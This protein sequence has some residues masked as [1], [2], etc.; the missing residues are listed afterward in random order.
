MVLPCDFRVH[1]VHPVDQFGNRNFD[2]N[3]FGS[4]ISTRPGPRTLWHC[5]QSFVGNHVKPSEKLVKIRPILLKKLRPCEPEN[6]G[7]SKFAAIIT[8]HKS[9]RSALGNNAKPHNFYELAGYALVFLTD[10]YS[11][12]IDE[13]HSLERDLNERVE[14]CFGPLDDKPRK[15]APII[16]GQ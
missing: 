1:G 11:F 12:V 4:S 15:D 7:S 14:R 3:P 6:L 5:H 10:D 13:A 9:D 2:L 8:T 16:V